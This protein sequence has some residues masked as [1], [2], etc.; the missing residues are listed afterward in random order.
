MS[1][2]TDTL[3]V[4]RD[5]ATTTAVVRRER[6][7]LGKKTVRIRTR[8]SNSAGRLCCEF[9]DLEFVHGSQ[10]FTRIFAMLSSSRVKTLWPARARLMAAMLAF[11]A[12]GCAQKPRH[13]SQATVL[14][15]A[16]V[17]PPAS[18]SGS[19]AAP[20]SGPRT[21][22][23]EAELR[24]AAELGRLRASSSGSRQ[25]CAQFRGVELA[26]GRARRQAR[27]AQHA[28]ECTPEATRVVT[29]VETPDGYFVPVD[30]SLDLCS[31]R[32][33]FVPRDAA[34]RPLP[35]SDVLEEFD[36]AFTV[37]LEADDLDNDGVV[38]ALL[39]RGWAHPEGVGD[40]QDA[41]V[42]EPSGEQ[43]RLPFNDLKDVDGDGRIDAI[44]RF[45]S[46]TNAAGCEPPD[47][48]EAWVPRTL[49]GPDIVLHRLSGFKFSLT[50]EVSRRARAKACKNPGTSPVARR[51]GEVD[52]NETMR[53][54]A[55]QLAAG[56]DPT[57]IGRALNDACS[58][59][60]ERPTD[61]KK[62]RPGVCFWRSTLLDVPAVF[63][64][65]EP[66]LDAPTSLPGR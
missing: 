8:F 6:A 37:R 2:L 54:A 66:W 23:E 16:S 24:D 41:H 27:G 32:L 48:F 22:A 25:G 15:K 39:I 38:E 21:P 29:C 28:N 9:I 64:A 63:A 53:R 40:G 62:R 7:P 51:G 31:Y 52:E 44:V 4:P 19:A 26:E 12:A 30:Q 61:C 20:G 57:T 11:L 14:A 35:V 3:Q 50:D 18:P 45:A 13:T 17:S 10:R 5:L 49:Y 33:W 59:D 42:V 47:A 60:Y 1:L 65:L 36:L 55:C 34:R 56:G 46:T 58:R 43:R